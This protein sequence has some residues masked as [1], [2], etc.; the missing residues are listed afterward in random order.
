M[1]L[2]EQERKE[3]L[4][5]LFNKTAHTDRYHLGIL[6]WNA[7]CNE[8]GETARMYMPSDQSDDAQINNLLRVLFGGL[9]L[10]SIQ[11]RE[12]D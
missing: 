1:Q 9:T 11:E 2:T 12:G 3:A 10:D 7:T 6:L 8:L 4:R 5:K